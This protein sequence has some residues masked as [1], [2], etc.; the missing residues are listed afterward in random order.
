MDAE[1]RAGAEAGTA[2]TKSEMMIV[3]AARELFARTKAEGFQPA[4][5]FFDTVTL[6][7]GTD[8]FM[9]PEGNLKSSHTRN[10]FLAIFKT[11]RR[12]QR[13]ARRR[14]LADRCE[15]R[16]HTEQVC[17]AAFERHSRHRT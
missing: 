13:R 10:A 14:T 15:P 7:I 9:D 11:R 8:G 1:R 3:A 12:F 2:F 5:L 4:E 16:G 17:R 6:G